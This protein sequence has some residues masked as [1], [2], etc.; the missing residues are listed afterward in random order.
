MKARGLYYYKCSTNGCKCN[1][2]ATQLNTLFAAELKKLTVKEELK[3]AV[4]YELER[5][6]YEVSKDSFELHNTLQRQLTEINHKIDALQESFFITREMDRPTFD[7]FNARYQAERAKIERQLADCSV[8]ISNI[9]EYV[10]DAVT[11]SSKL[12]TVWT[13]GGITLKEDR[14]KLVYPEGI[15]YDRKNEAFRTSE[16]NI[17]FTIIESNSV[18]SDDNKKGT[19]YLIDRLSLSADWTG[20]EPATSAVTGRHSNQLNY[21][22]IPSK[23]GWQR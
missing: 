16:K 21:Q 18:T 14:Q 1:K 17:I 13:S 3:T 7:K 9:S 11:L 12:N 5:F 4:Q 10:Q 19:N 2:S 20:L 15:V 8:T 23:L 6:Y 22:S